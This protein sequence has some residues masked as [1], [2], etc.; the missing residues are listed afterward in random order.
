MRLIAKT[1]IN[2]QLVQ[3]KWYYSMSLV[4][5]LVHFQERLTSELNRLQSQYIVRRT[6]DKIKKIDIKS[7]SVSREIV[8][9]YHQNLRIII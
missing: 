5:P 1:L 2:S 9:I 8:L 6:G 3:E 4:N 7:T